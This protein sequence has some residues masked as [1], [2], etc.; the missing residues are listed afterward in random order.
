MFYGM[1]AASCCKDSSMQMEMKI[2]TA[3]CSLSFIIFDAI[4]HDQK[5]FM[6]ALGETVSYIKVL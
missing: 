5:T 2:P 4:N 3:V 1:S 6:F